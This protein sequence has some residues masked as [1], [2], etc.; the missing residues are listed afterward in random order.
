MIHIELCAFECRVNLLFH[1]L[2]GQQTFNKRCKH[3][4]NKWS[5]DNGHRTTELAIHA[6]EK[7]RQKSA[8]RK[9]FT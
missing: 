2:N 1:L 9:Q 5:N 7:S 4:P 3:A 8:Y 6:M